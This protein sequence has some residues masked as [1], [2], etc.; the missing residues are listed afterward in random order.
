M[1]AFLARLLVGLC[2]WAAFVAVA[3]A[4]ARIV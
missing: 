2:V 3:Y 4:G 1:R